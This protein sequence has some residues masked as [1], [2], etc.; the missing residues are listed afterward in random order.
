MMN[1]FIRSR[2]VEATSVNQTL[3]TVGTHRTARKH[4]RFL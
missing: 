2:C 3:L 1:V 4:G